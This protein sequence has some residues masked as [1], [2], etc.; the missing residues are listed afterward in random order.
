MEAPTLKTIYYWPNG[1]WVEDKTT[2]DLACES[3][4]TAYTVL[5]LPTSA[6][7]DKEVKQRLEVAE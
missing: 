1:L 7:I 4:F 3:G 6:D 2:A 5:E